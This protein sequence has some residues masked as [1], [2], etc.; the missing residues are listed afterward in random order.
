[1]AK[2]FIKKDTYVG[3]TG[4]TL[5]NTVAGVKSL[6]T[7]NTTNKNNISNNKTDITNLKNK[8]NNVG[9]YFEA[10]GGSK[11]GITPNTSHEIQSLTLDPGVYIIN[12][13]FLYRNQDLRY[14]LSLYDVSLSAY[15]KNGYVEATITAIA[16][17][18][19]RETIKM[20]L[21]ISGDKTITIAKRNIK[22]VR[23]I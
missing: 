20:Y 3:D 23:I 15:D 10:I 16:K 11:S 22:A 21:W 8:V 14:Y 19:A 18:T 5:E 6:K 1:M 9:K 12:G 4:Y 13:T 17:L 2:Y 7:D